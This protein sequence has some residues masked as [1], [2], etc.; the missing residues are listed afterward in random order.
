MMEN[1]SQDLISQHLII[2]ELKGIREALESIANDLHEV[3]MEK[4][5]GSLL[6]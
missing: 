3:L 2:R 5:P 1:T 4:L 6:V